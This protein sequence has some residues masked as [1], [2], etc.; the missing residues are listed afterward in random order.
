M[1]LQFNKAVVPC[2]RTVKR[3]L[4]IQEQ[5][6][7][8]RLTDGMPDI[9]K[10]LASWG[11]MVIRGKEWRSGSAGVSGGVMVWVL[12]VPEDGGE[13]QSI[14]TWLPFQMKWDVP[15]TQ[16]DG[17]ILAVPTL[18]SVDAR[19]LSARKLMI[20]A[21]VSILGEVMIPG[22]VEIYTPS[23]V[24]E[25]VQ[26]LKNSYPVQLARES[27]E[28]AFMLDEI[29]TLPASVPGLRK[30]VRYS[31][32]PV[33]VDM[34]VVSDKLVIRGVATLAILYM[35]VDGQLHSWD[36]E[37]PFSQY[38]ELEREYDSGADARVRLAVT[39]LELEQG[40]EENLNLKAGLTAQYVIY[41]RPIIEV[42]EDMYSPRQSVK[43]DVSVLQVPSILDRFA[44]AVQAEHTVDVDGISAVDTV[45]YPD[46]PQLHREGDKV[47]AELTG[48]FQLLGY[49]D[50]GALQ[51]AV[52]RWEGGWQMNASGDTQV[53]IT[54]E[55]G[56]RPQATGSGG[57]ANVRGEMLLEV[58]TSDTGGIS[59]V[60]GAELGELA[61]PDPARP[62]LVLRKA[63]EQRLWDIAK[64]T[65]STVAAIQ[66]ANGLQQEP[67]SEQML[68]IPVN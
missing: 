58:Q 22:D 23:D 20:R 36:F 19:S 65:G 51:S 1:Q 38:A 8:V 63:G 44:E 37:L 57:T 59:M 46:Q 55:P 6:Q 26:V 17:T 40:E 45:F 12:Y 56:A 16:R 33:L 66:K 7:E 62:S 50:V 29:L 60:T 2:L 24:P 53:D 14:E 54:V 15:D 47:T 21:G 67:D 10:V 32:R 18:R 9:G 34:K 13:P 27:G 49:D 64:S 43:P 25:D 39:A 52:S 4:Q 11:Q 42:V 5:T 35:G 48:L 30:L 61:E 28:K 3:E 31:V 68:L 41:D